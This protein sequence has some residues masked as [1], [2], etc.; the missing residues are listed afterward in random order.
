MYAV[1][2]FGGFVGMDGQ[3]LS[4]SVAITEYGTELGDYVTGITESQL[5]GA[6]KYGNENA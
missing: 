1:L 5:K 3:L 2:I 6:L 4:A